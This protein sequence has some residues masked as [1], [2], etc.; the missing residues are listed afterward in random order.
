MQY[1]RLLSENTWIQRKRSYPN[2]SKHWLEH[3]KYLDDESNDG[4]DNGDSDSEDAEISPTLRGSSDESDDG[5]AE[6]DS[7]D[8]S[9]A[10]D[11]ETESISDGE[12][13]R[14]R[15]KREHQVEKP[16]A[17][18]FTARS[19]RQWTSEEPP[20]RK[21]SVASILRQR[22]GIGRA[23]MGIQTVQEAFQLLITQEMVLILVKETNQRTHLIMEQ[24]N[25]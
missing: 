17:I 5:V 14:R 21:V 15:A 12:P 3:S 16:A 6:K 18:I 2:Q 9:D 7:G 22:N 1:A 23:T 20:K 11:T 8:E 25:K 4:D 24:W 10:S 19:G 13:P